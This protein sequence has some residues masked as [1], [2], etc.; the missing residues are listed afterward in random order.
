MKQ[1]A[2]ILFLF[3][4]IGFASKVYAKV[5]VEQWQKDKN[6]FFMHLTG[7]A[8]GLSWANTALESNNQ[9]RLYCPPATISLNFLNDIDILENIIRN[10]RFPPDTPIGMVLLLGYQDTLPCSN[11]K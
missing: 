8:T 7:I 2:R 3:G 9:T 5:T 11:Q 6:E 10:R 4:M 1:L